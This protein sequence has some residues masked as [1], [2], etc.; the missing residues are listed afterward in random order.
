MASECI[1]WENESALGTCLSAM[2]SKKSG[3]LL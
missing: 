2:L 3:S 1:Y